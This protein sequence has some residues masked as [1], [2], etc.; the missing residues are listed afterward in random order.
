M[1]ETQG[2]LETENMEKKIHS[3]SEKIGLQAFYF[4]CNVQ[5]WNRPRARVV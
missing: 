5:Q 4:F 1:E 2:V 3:V